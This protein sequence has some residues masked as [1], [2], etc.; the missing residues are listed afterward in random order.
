VVTDNYYKIWIRKF[1]RVDSDPRIQIGSG[2]F[3]SFGYPLQPYQAFNFVIW[4]TSPLVKSGSHRFD[5]RHQTKL[6]FFYFS[7]IFFCK[8]EQKS[9]KFC[10]FFVYFSWIV[11]CKN[12]QK[13]KILSKTCA[14]IV[15]FSVLTLQE[16]VLKEKES[17]QN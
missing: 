11:F 2:I 15:I 12:E 16:A 13:F 17:K 10:H 8:N 6:F 7:W 9:L 3:G 1:G 14:N 4:V 5:S